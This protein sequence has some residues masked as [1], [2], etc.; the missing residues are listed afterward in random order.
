MARITASERAESITRLRELLRPGDTLT[1][2]LRHR[3]SSGMYRAIDVY[4]FRCER[5]TVER[6]W[7]SYHIARALS[8]ARWDDRHEAVG[9][10]GAGM[11]MGFHIVHSLG[12][13]LWP[14]GYRCTGKGCPSNDHRNGPHYKPDGRRKHA[15]GGYA[16]S[17]EWLG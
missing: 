16:L 11:D 6:S 8:G 9:V 17:H 5:G 15:S 3:S 10:T 4:K 13:V 12:Y 1:T 2:V 7:L 14:D